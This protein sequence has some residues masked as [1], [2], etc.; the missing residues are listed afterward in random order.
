M[1]GPRTFLLSLAGTLHRLTVGACVLLLAVSLG[2]QLA[3]V[4]LRYGFDTGSLW[5]QD[6]ALWSFAALALFAYSGRHRMGRP[7]PDRPPPR[8]HVP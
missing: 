3:S 5:L 7:C 6:L 2:A 4:V 1:Q 8:G